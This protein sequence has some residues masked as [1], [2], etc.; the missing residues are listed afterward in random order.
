[1]AIVD[2]LHGLLRIAEAECLMCVNN[3]I[4]NGKWQTGHAASSAK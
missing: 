4:A 1:M 3:G 2:M